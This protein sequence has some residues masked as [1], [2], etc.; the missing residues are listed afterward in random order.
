MNQLEHKEL[1]LECRECGGQRIL[2]QGIAVLNE[3]IA[4]HISAITVITCRTC[5]APTEEDE[6]TEEM[7]D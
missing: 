1:S 5:D 3:G 4:R 7:G 2:T 6:P